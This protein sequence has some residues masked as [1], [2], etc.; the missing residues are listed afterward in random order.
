MDVHVKQ[1]RTTSYASWNKP[2][3]P[4]PPVLIRML[5]YSRR[6]FQKPEASENGYSIFIEKTPRGVRH[7]KLFNALEGYQLLG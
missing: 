4:C 5:L 2:R 7:V 6:L 3:D 1:R